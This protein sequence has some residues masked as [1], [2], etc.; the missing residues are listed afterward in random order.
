MTVLLSSRVIARGSPDAATS[1]WWDLGRKYLLYMKVLWEASIS[2]RIAAKLQNFQNLF[3]VIPSYTS[4]FSRV[5]AR[6]SPDAATSTWWDLGRKYLLYMKILWQASISE[7]IAAYFKIFEILFM[8]DHRETDHR[9]I[10][11]LQRSLR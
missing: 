1:T 6:G 11:I 8:L 4:Q 10:R 9:G 3:Y 2:E 7:R 5:I